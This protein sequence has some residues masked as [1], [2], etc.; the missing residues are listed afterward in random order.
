MN[1]YIW[2]LKAIFNYYED[3][4]VLSKYIFLNPKS[5]NECKHSAET[6]VINYIDK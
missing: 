2:L 5:S 3:L 6:L 4:I 1:G